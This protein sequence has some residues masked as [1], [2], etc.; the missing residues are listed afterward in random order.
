VQLRRL[1]CGR[2]AARFVRGAQFE[3]FDHTNRDAV[4]RRSWWRSPQRIEPELAVSRYSKGLLRDWPRLGH[5]PI[6]GE[7]LASVSWEIAQS[8]PAPRTFGGTWG[9]DWRRTAGG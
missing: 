5:G 4:R 2:A 3:L 7:A 8:G 9:V 6:V 1:L